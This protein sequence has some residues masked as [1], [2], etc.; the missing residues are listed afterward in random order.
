MELFTKALR[1]TV[2]KLKS[3]NAY[4]QGDPMQL[5][6]FGLTMARKK[7]MATD[8]GRKAPKPIQGMINAAFQQLS[9]LAHGIGLLKNHGIKPFYVNVHEYQ[10]SVQSGQEKGKTASAIVN[11]ESF[12]TMMN[13]VRTWTSNPDFIGH[14]KLEYLREVVLNHFLDAGEGRQ[15]SDVP[16]SAT[17]IMIFASY[18]DSTEEICRVL[19]RNEPMIR[20][21]VFVG[22]A[23]SNGSE[24]MDQRRQNA[25]IQDFKS[26]KY[27]TLV[28]TSI[29][30]EGLDIGTVD[31]IICYDSSSSPIR[32]LQRIGRTGRKRLGRVV[33]LLMKG[34]EENDYAKSQD[35]YL[36]IQKTIADT[37][38][39]TYHDE[40]SPRI[41][42]KDA[43]PT[44]DKRPVEIPVENSQPVDLNEK[45]KRGKGKTKRPPKKFHMPDG[46]RTNFV[47]ASKLNSDDDDDNDGE[48]DV[49]VNKNVP[50]AKKAR[51]SKSASILKNARP[52]SPKPEPAPLPFMGDVLLSSTQL[53]DW[54]QKYAQT[55]H[56]D[57]DDTIHVPDLS[58]SEGQLH[59][60]GQTKFIPH[61]RALIIQRMMI[62]IQAI[63]DDRVD[64]MHDILD[65]SL[66]E[67]SGEANH[68]LCDPDPATIEKTIAQASSAVVRSELPSV[69]TTK[70]RDAQKPAPKAALK[71]ASKAST[72]KPTRPPKAKA[73]AASE[74]AQTAVG[75]PRKAAS[76]R[77]LVTYHSSA[78]EGDESS[79]EPTPAEMR[80]GTQGIDLGSCD[81]SG[82]DSDD[83]SPDSEL[84]GFIARSSDPIEMASS[85]QDGL[86]RRRK[87]MGLK[88]KVA[89]ARSALSDVEEIDSANSCFDA[90][91]ADLPVVSKG[92]KKRIVE[93]SESDE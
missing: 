81:T 12:T 20:P 49:E 25:V 52:I 58:N 48:E 77:P 35:N 51:P 88:R 50:A 64:R 38:R 56:D 10:K 4:F 84:D 7:W 42:P 91:D 21:H 83:D 31:L 34:K 41:L 74:T 70:K 14:P 17:R 53:D 23:A 69:R 67:S 45:R 75:R 79:P 66:L 85:S 76:S 33:L 60:L 9:K 13:T 61:R 68:R 86:P 46:V 1:D 28:A 89:P 65:S 40:Q 44:V 72:V 92:K 55:L 11:S 29:G 87:H 3:H 8:A 2:N 93:D 24:G 57:N 73:T 18:R 47:R 71:A 16:P 27:N 62:R 26:G 80:I 19:K 43:K 5:T 22:Q 90:S 32:M 37:S 39:Y 82:E 15:G 63:D 30:E 6:A 59:S 54:R 78:Q 36:W